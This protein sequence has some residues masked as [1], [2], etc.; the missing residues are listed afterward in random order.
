LFGDLKDEMAGFTG[1][2][3]EDIL[4]EILRLSQENP[5]ETL[6]AV[7]HEEITRLECIIHVWDHKIHSSAFHTADICRA[8]SQS[9]SIKQRNRRAYFVVPQKPCSVI[10]RK[11]CH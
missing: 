9:L 8:Y 3:R 6:I 7:Y 2:S 10:M 11:Q 4:S 5:K 1:N